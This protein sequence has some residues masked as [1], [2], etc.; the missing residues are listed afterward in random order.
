MWLYGTWL[1]YMF[2]VLSFPAISKV[3]IQWNTSTS[4]TYYSEVKRDMFWGL[5]MLQCHV[6]CVIHK[7]YIL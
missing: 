6:D 1:L 2:C 5:G 4:K 3:E 7:S